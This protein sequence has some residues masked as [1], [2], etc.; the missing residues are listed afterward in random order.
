VPLTVFV[1]LV[2]EIT[3][4]LTLRYRVMDRFLDSTRTIFKVKEGHIQATIIFF[5]FF[6]AEK[7]VR[8]DFHFTALYF[9]IE[10]PK[11]LGSISSMFYEQLL[12][13]Q[14]PKAKKRLAT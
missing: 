5:F 8:P 13:T 6:L 9:E 14:I 1:L 7:Y 11:F 2:F 3:V 4:Q 12:R 10:S